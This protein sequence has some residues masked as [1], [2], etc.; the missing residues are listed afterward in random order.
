MK[1]V[2]VSPSTLFFYEIT[3]DILDTLPF[4]LESAYPFPHRDLLGLSW[5]CESI[6]ERSDI[7]TM[8]NSSLITLGSVL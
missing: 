8:F 7:L 1:S 4:I 6:S 2:S 3:L 5:G